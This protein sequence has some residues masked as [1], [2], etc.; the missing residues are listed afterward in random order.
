MKRGELIERIFLLACVAALWP[1][2]LGWR[3][4]AVRLMQLAVLVVL[5]VLAVRKIRQW[6]RL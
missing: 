5:I 2:I 6:R 3:H 4:W 1:T